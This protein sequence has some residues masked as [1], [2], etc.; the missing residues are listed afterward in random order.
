[1][2]NTDNDTAGVTVIGDQRA[3]TTEAGGTAT[4]TVV[5]DEPA[6]GGRDDRRSASSD[7]T[8]GTVSPAALTFTAANWNTA[9]TVTVTG[10]NDF[11]D[12]GDMAYSDRDGRGD[13]R[14]RALQRDRPGRRGGHQHGRRHGR[15]SRSSPTQRADDDRGGRHGDV[16]RRADSQPTADVTHRRSAPA[17]RPRA[18]CRPRR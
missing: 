12:D 6:D 2:T 1:M 10:V 11:L 14:R 18:R 15:G 16:H 17:T 9:Q 4:F 8:E 13:Q 7:A 5:L 3:D